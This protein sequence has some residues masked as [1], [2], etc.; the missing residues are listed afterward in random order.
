MWWKSVDRGMMAHSSPEPLYAA[1]VRIPDHRQYNTVHPLSSVVALCVCEM[2]CGARSHFSIAQWGRE[3]AGEVGELLGFRRSTPCH[4][5][6][7]NVLQG[8]NLL[9]FASVLS[10]WIRKLVPAGKPNACVIDGKKLRGIHKL[11][12]VHLVAILTHK[13]GLPLAQLG[14]TDKDAELTAA[15]DLLDRLDMHGRR[16]ILPGA[17]F[18]R[19]WSKRGV[20]FHSGEG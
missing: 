7:H 1:L 20:L 11:P 16:L 19:K 6:I 2:F 10:D 17:T 8:V 4:A 5:S 3:H 15:R 12:G 18:A 14:A 9:A 13:L